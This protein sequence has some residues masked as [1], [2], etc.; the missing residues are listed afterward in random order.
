MY[1][2]GDRVKIVDKWGPGCRQSLGGHM[3]KWLGKVM[4][5]RAIEHISGF[6]IYRMVED[7]EENIY[8]ESRGWA[9][10]PTAIEGLAPPVVVDGISLLDTVS[11]ADYKTLIPANTNAWWLRMPVPLTGRLAIV[12][13][14]SEKVMLNAGDRE[15]VVGVRPVLRLSCI[16]DCLTPGDKISLLGLT[17]TVLKSDRKN[18]EMLVLCDDTIAHRRFDDKS[19]IW[20]ASELKWWLEEWLEYSALGRDDVIVV[21]KAEKGNKDDDPFA[22]I[23]YKSDREE[24]F[25]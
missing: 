25:P 16:L 13:A 1:S 18:C 10:F 15:L 19:C 11:Y 3:D 5:I 22:D 8:D 12:R 24:S 17:W 2:V 14:D 20:E 4:T 21:F 6:C 7:F 23:V 9:W